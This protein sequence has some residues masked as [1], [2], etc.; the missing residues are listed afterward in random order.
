VS[1]AI[2]FI[3][4]QGDAPP[5]TYASPLATGNVRLASE[6]LQRLAR[7]RE[8]LPATIARGEVPDAQK[9]LILIIYLIKDRRLYPFRVPHLAYQN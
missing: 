2:V 7:T 9:S 3:I 8:T 1:R 6:N 4:I 5:G